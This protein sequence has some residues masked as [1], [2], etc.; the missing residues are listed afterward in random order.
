MN[1]AD[2][3]RWENNIHFVYISVFYY[4]ARPVQGISA[5]FFYAFFK[6]LTLK[7]RYKALN[8][9]CVPGVIGNYK[10]IFLNADWKKV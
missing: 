3:K 2:Y 8:L 10:V 4:L 1:C 5:H 9:G 6:F 7:H